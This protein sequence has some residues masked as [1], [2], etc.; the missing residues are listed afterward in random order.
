MPTSCRGHALVAQRPT[1]LHRGQAWK[2]L[3][4]PQ[5]SALAQQHHHHRLSYHY[6]RCHQP[7]SANEK[8][9][10][11]EKHIERIVA[12]VDQDFQIFYNVQIE[13]LKGE[14]FNLGCQIKYKLFRSRQMIHDTGSGRCRGAN[15]QQSFLRVL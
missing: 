10:V 8:E 13:P 2:T 1:R 5:P 7:L 11:E 14:D 3:A 4:C 9:T 6:H 15:V 12:E